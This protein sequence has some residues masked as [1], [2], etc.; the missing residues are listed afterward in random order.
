MNRQMTREIVD[1]SNRKQA[2]DE[3]GKGGGGDG[4]DTI[5]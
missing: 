5:Q 3:A 2:E 4:N 1:K